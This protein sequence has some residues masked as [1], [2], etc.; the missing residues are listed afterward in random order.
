[1]NF[2][3]LI[4]EI[5][6]KVS[7]EGYKSDEQIVYFMKQIK[8][9]AIKEM[10][11]ESEVRELLKRSL[12]VIY[13][14]T[15]KETSVVRTHKSIP[16]FTIDKVRPEL[17]NQ[18]DKSIMA[19]AN[20]IK[21]NRE[22]AVQKTLRRFSGWATAIPEGGGIVDKIETK[23]TIIKA[24]K[25]LPYVERRVLI[26]QGHKLTAALNNIIATGGGAIAV[27]WHSHWK[28]AGYDY[29]EDHRERDGEIYMIPNN[30]A[31]EQGL[32]KLGGHKNYDTITAF[33]EEVNCRCYGQYLYNLRDLPKE[34]LTEKGQT[35]MLEAKKKS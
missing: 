10:L 30:W 17:R 6:N 27:I 9:M 22:E 23:E 13:S 24:L 21:L 28:Q 20:L 31:L 35:A 34:M 1:M 25:S 14:R 7:N 29:R 11:Q 5:I 18:L 15:T 12:E 26:D 8:S 3:K 16:Q 2:Y 19:S 4:T 33:G 32:V